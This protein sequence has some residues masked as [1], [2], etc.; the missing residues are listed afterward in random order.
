MLLHRRSRNLQLLLQYNEK[1]KLVIK[2]YIAKKLQNIQ[3]YKAYST[4]ILHFLKIMHSN[5]HFTVSCEHH[6]SSTYFNIIKI[7]RISISYFSVSI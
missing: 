2:Y 5:F 7:C 6:F 1:V 4:K 3:S